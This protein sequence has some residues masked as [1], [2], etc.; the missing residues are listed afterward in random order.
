[1]S[2]GTRELL[3]GRALNFV[4]GTITLY[5]YPFQGSS[6]IGRLADF[7]GYTL[8]QPHNPNLIAKAGLGYSPFARRY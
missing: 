8:K 7:P 3:P 4:Y 6:T 2:R 5:G 1:M